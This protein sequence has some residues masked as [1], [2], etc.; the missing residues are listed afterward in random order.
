VDSKKG[1]G[2]DF[3]IYR[4][5]RS[6]YSFVATALMI[7]V[8]V[9]V[10]QTTDSPS[11]L[12]IVLIP[13]NIVSLTL[14][15]LLG[16]FV[17]RYNKKYLMLISEVI[18]ILPLGIIVWLFFN[19]SLSIVYLA[20]L[21]AVFQCF[22]SIYNSTA[23]VILPSLVKTE[24]LSEATAKIQGIQAF[25]EIMGGVCGGI[26]VATVSFGHL[27]LLTI[28]ALIVSLITL[29]FIR[30]KE[31]KVASTV[32]EED[33][34]TSSWFSEFK[35]GMSYLWR[36]KVLLSLTLYLALM[37][38]FMGPLAI[39]LE[40]MVL[41]DLKLEADYIGYLLSGIAVGHLI[42]MSLFGKVSRHIP[43]PYFTAIFIALMGGCLIGMGLSSNYWVV[44]V[45]VILLG[46]SNGL[47]AI[48]LNTLLVSSIDADYRGRVINLIGS[49]IAVLAPLS[50][51]VVAYLLEFT[52]SFDVYLISG[53][54]VLLVSPILAFMPA[55]KRFL[56]LRPEKSAKWLRW[57]YG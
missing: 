13:M 4:L 35:S 26:I 55:L 56:K 51:A 29:L 46:V 8:S 19:D 25:V 42:A 30:V 31:D 36:N 24:R 40:V 43:Q 18:S 39:T 16:P 6:I 20:I 54:F 48:P 9:W 5:G 38:F 57:V 11:Q 37:A 1:L 15:P 32:E 27:I 52:S 50:I 41:N 28:V 7:G 45:L 53:V 3:W 49:F 2:K 34:S 23:T 14:L 47:L 22:R 21:F 10:L 33:N 17:D 12:A 44:L